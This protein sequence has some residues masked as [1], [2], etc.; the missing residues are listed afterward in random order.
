VPER[1]AE[2][3]WMV[4]YHC[5]AMYLLTGSNCLDIGTGASIAFMAVTI[6]QGIL[7]LS[8]GMAGNVQEAHEG[9]TGTAPG[10]P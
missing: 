10:A 7:V 8:K 6:V 2:K 4:L 1:F 9:D 3:S 5:I